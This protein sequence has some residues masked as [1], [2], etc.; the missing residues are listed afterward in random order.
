MVNLQAQGP[1]RSQYRLSI[2]CLGRNRLVPFGVII[3]ETRLERSNHI[4][5]GKKLHRELI[6][7]ISCDLLG[8]SHLLQANILC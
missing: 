4:I 6:L 7:M 1:N 5:I 2:S 3:L 8:L